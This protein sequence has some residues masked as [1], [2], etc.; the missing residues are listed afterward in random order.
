MKVY[1]RIFITVKTC[2]GLGVLIWMVVCKLILDSHPHEQGFGIFVWM[3]TWGSLWDSHLHGKNVWFLS[4]WAFRGGF[5]V[6]IWMWV[7]S[8]SSDS[9]PGVGYL[10]IFIYIRFILGGWGSIWSFY[11][12]VGFIWAHLMHIQHTLTPP[13]PPRECTISW[14]VF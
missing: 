5:G 10:G 2:E 7:W 8:L 1:F 4:G 3:W 11:L 6:F 14:D 13:L 12:E 9:H